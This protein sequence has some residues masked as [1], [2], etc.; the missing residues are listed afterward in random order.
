MLRPLFSDRYQTFEWQGIPDQVHIGLVVA[1]HQRQNPQINYRAQGEEQKRPPITADPEN[2]PHH[3]CRQ[4]GP[5]KDIDPGDG[6][7]VFVYG[8]IEGDQ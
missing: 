7:Q 4:G 8:I 2:A 1:A 5:P 6:G 3:R